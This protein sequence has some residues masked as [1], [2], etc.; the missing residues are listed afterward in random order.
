MLATGRFGRT[1]PL[2]STRVQV[3]VSLTCASVL[4][5]TRPSSVPAQTASPPPTPI[6]DTT[7]PR[8]PLGAAPVQPVVRSPLIAVQRTCPAAG[9]L[10]LSVRYTRWVP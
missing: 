7:Q 5:R 6:A 8:A 2:L 9:A 4:R 1:L 3:G 10:A